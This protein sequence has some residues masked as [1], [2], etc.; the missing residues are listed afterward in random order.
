[1]GVF[2][3]RDS[4]HTRTAA[5]GSGPAANRHQNSIPR[6][7]QAVYKNVNGRMELHVE[8]YSDACPFECYVVL[9]DAVALPDALAG[10]LKQ[11]CGRIAE[12]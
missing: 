6:M 11:F 12:D 4:L 10:M 8:R 5:D 2:I 9:R 3:I 7:N 1:M